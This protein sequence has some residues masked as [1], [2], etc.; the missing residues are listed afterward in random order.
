MNSQQQ[1]A[2]H[3]SNWEL[4]GDLE[5]PLN[6]DQYEAIHEWLSQTLE[7]LKLHGDLVRRVETS[8]QEAARRALETHTDKKMQHIHLRIH[9]PMER[10]SK[11]KTWGFFRVEKIEEESR[12]GQIPA[13]ATELFL[14]L[15]AH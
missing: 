2:S 6:D 3:N 8:L 15:E 1:P 4:L 13:H 11:G 14:Y 10:T 7:P 9:V 12:N 5:L